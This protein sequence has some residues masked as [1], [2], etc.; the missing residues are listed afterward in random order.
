MPT[1]LLAAV[2][3]VA[4]V[5]GAV[6][7]RGRLDQRK[8]DKQVTPVLHC[9]SELI[10]LCR[11]IS[12]R[13]PEINVII[14]PAGKSIEMLTAAG[15]DK[16]FDGWITI[17]PWAVMADAL[18]AQRSLPAHF[19]PERVDLGRTP[20]GLAVWPDRKAAMEGFC[21]GVLTWK[22]LGQV[23][24]KGQ[25]SSVGGGARPEWGPIKINLAEA[26]DYAVGL[27][28]L[29][30]ATQDYFGGRTDLSTLDLEDAGYQEWLS[31]LKKA[32]PVTPRRFGEV[33]ATGVSIAD[34]H[35]S[36]E[37]EILGPLQGYARSPKPDLIY[38]SPVMTADLVLATVPGRTGE[39]LREIVGDDVRDDVAEAGW[40]VTGKDDPK[41]ATQPLPRVNG[42]PDAGLL[43]ALREAWEAA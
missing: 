14:S 25:W 43:I 35:A 18:R 34:A 33:L 41:G 29:A 24:A 17:E 6:F 1:R 32:T 11:D 39:R 16:G 3:A 37:A 30:A 20:V 23:A 42:L 28:V 12:N 21:K 40:R 9:V 8:E 19:A 27:T 2:A 4:M 26:G 10:D 15:G 36:T 38:P 7:V 22:C 31:G 5:V 13:S